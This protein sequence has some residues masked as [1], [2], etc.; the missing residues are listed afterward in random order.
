MRLYGINFKTFKN[1]RFEEAQSKKVIALNM[2]P[3]GCSSTDLLKAINKAL[4]SI[5]V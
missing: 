4:K 5:D 1:I 2:I 3:W